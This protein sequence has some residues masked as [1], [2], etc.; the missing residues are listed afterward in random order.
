MNN[1]LPKGKP[2]LCMDFDGVIHSY[3]SGWQGADVIP[4]PPVKGALEFLEKATEY[5][6]VHIF[7]SRSHQ[8][9]G[10]EAMENWLWKQVTGE[11]YGPD[12]TIVVPV[13]VLKIKW[14]FVKPAAFL[15][16]D[17]RGYCFT[18]EFPDP[19]ALLEFKPWHKKEV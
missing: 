1:D 4:D 6:E 14:S 8:A 15:S 11:D 7:S 5:F 19:K 17:D 2:I 13:W 12:E 16:I 18:R 3:T 9:G 10:I